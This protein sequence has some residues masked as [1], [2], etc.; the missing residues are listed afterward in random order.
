MSGRFIFLKKKLDPKAAKLIKRLWKQVIVRNNSKIS[1]F[2][3]KPKD[4]KLIFVAAEHGNIEFLTIL[5]REYPDLLFEVDENNYTIFHYAVK[6]RQN[7]IFKLIHQIGSFKDLIA[8]LKH[9]KKGNNILH[10]AGILAP[11]DRLSIVSGAA[12]Q[13][14]RELLWF[15]EVR[16][17]IHPLDAQ[18]KNK[19]GK[20][21]EVLFSEQHKDLKKEGEKWMKDTANS[22]MIVA[23]LIATV[24]FA[25]AFTIPGGTK[26]D[27][28]SPN[29]LLKDSFTIFAIA[30]GASL[31]L[32]SCSVLTFL[33][34]LTSR[35]AEKDFIWRLPT[36]LLIGL[37]TLFLSV[38]AM[39]AVFCTTFFIVFDD[40]KRWC[41]HLVTGMASGPAI[42]YIILQFRLICDIVSSTYRRWALFKPRKHNFSFKEEK[43][44]EPKKEK[45]LSVIKKFKW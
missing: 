24:A 16:E 26:Q 42:L 12:L 3:E 19:K 32:S 10:L 20:T 25:A 35:Y 6:Y 15:E 37:L 8:T 9:E 11:P 27:T 23:T 21:P 2:I 44:T 4:R 29:F 30:D 36:M 17:I 31:A 28:G 40:G 13:L 39:M 18:E 1:Q 22:C 43:A 38:V 14:Q 41:A 7:D 5:I 34:I 45:L 33:S